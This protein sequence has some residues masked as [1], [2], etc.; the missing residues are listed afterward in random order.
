MP[1]SPTADA[2]MKRAIYVG[3]DIWLLNYGMT[4]TYGMADGNWG[5]WGPVFEFRADGEVWAIP[6]PRSDVYI[7]TED[8]T[9]H[10]PKP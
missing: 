5:K 2:E 9:K 1:S 3:E 10:R 6:L 7:S 4:G 8:L